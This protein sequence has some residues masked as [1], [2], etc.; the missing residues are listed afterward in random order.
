VS[1]VCGFCME[2]ENARCDIA[3]VPVWPVGKRECAE[4]ATK[5]SSTDAHSAG[6]PARSSDEVP[7]RRG[8]DGAKGPAHQECQTE[9]PG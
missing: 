4:A 7:A 9:Q 3:L 5:A 6:G 2:R 8:G 1:P